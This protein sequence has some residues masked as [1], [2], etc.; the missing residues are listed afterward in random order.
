MTVAEQVT[1]VCA[2]HG[3]GPVWD[4]AA[5]VLRWVDMLCGD[6]LSM[7]P[8]DGGIARRHV[9]AVAA[10][11][12]PRGGGGLVIAV[13]RGFALLDPGASQP[14]TMPE[15]WT[16]PSV[17]MNDGGCDPQGRFY[18]GSMAYDAAPGRGAL[19]RLDPDG[20]THRVLT[21]VTISNG[22]AWSADGATAYYID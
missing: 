2:H 16:D 15:L 3:E 12:R 14:R 5:G 18:C 22:L 13:E 20:A 19:H 10:A 1:E 9:G 11:L 21:G 4:A 17:R 6:V 7:A 8:G